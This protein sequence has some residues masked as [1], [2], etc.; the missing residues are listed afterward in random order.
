MGR[1]SSFDD[2]AIQGFLDI[3]YGRR[4]SFLALS[5]LYDEKNWGVTTFHKDH[6]FPRS[7][8]TVTELKRAGIPEYSWEAYW[9]SR[10]LVG[11]LQLLTENENEEK[12]NKDFDEWLGTRDNGYRERHLIPDDQSLYHIGRFPDFVAAREDLI[13][14]R[15]ERV[16]TPASD[17]GTSR[18][19]SRLTRR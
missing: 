1:S 18:A 9:A 6:I 3:T 16:F 17:V 10:D 4:E 12:S 8:F 5:L 7:K 15:L 14:K 13:V 19:G 2:G 11:N